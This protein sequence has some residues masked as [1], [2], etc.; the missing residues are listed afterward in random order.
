MKIALVHDWL[1]DIGGAEKTLQSIWK[2][3][4][5][6]LF[7]LFS[8]AGS[9]E[10]IGIDPKRIR[11]S[12]LQALPGIT[13]SYRSVPFLF[14][15]AIASFDLRG[16]DV[17]ISSSHTAAKAVRTRPGQLHICYCYSP[18]RWAWDFQDQYLDRAGFRG[19]KAWLARQILAP[20]RRWDYATRNRPTDYIGI[21]RYIA[22]RIRRVYGREAT[23]IYPPVDVA[24]FTLPSP[25]AGE[26]RVR[27][28]FYL[29]AGRLVPY[30]RVDLVVETFRSLPDRQLVVIGDGPER[31]RVAA[32]AGRAPN[33]QLLGYQSLDVLKDHLQRA[34]AFIF[35]SEEDFGI[36]PVEAQAAGTPV[37]AFGRGAARETIIDGETGLFFDAQTPAALTD[38]IT[39]FEDRKHWKT[40]LIVRN[41]ERFSRAAFEREFRGFVEERIKAHRKGA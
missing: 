19:P 4:P 40:A 20:L 26:G 25:P 7:V 2:L 6:D 28:D 16:Y 13:R 36:A 30:K 31:A 39:R 1:V 3:Y 11:T 37:I 10:R 29:T 32:A 33:I 24:E 15:P 18:M 22:A 9:P 8:R 5:T 12:W 17:I 14:P 34:R 27:G 23:V 35:A 38:A 21:S 41:A